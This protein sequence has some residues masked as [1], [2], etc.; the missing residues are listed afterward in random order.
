MD[1]VVRYLAIEEYYG[2]NDYGFNLYKKMQKVRGQ[3][4]HNIERFSELIKSIEKHGFYRES[5][6]LVDLNMQLIDGSHRLA[7]ALYFNEERIPIRIQPQLTNIKYDIEWFR[8]AGF[9]DQEINIICEKQKD[10][11]Q[12]KGIYFVATLWPPVQ[13]YFDDI[14]K[15][16]GQEYIILSVKDY[17]FQNDQEFAAT[18]KG[19]YAVDDIEDW[20]ID[21]KI[22][23]M[24]DYDKKIRVITF[25]IG[26]PEF[27]AKTRNNKPI[28]MEV[29]RIKKKYREKYSKKIDNYF[30]NIIMHIGDNYEHS[31]HMMKTMKKF[32][33]NEIKI[34]VENKRDSWM[35][36][37]LS[38]LEEVTKKYN[39]SKSDFCIVGSSILELKNIRKSNDVDIVVAYAKRR[40]ITD[41]N[42]ACKISK[43]V[44]IVGRGWAAC[45][46]IDDEELITNSKYHF[47]INGF[48]FVKLEL[49]YLK[50]LN[51]K[52][53]KDIEDI[54]MIEE[55]FRNGLEWDHSII[56]EIVDKVEAKQK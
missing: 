30:Y 34:S 36:K 32:N 4:L 50:K 18:I 41:T 39:L 17:T 5:S 22:E 19:L 15:E 16:L 12:K 37:Y 25:D 49:L 31:E 1:T 54:R 53:E 7:Y 24:R 6:I 56:Q 10:I 29:E 35:T 44:E 21:K 43:N 33:Y 40:E 47:E 48:K 26:D 2:K 14:T 52:R 9:N 27:R 38:E 45:L 42:R 23:Y 20:K 3:N 28:S 11:I 51:M 8:S 55:C 13:E 46:C